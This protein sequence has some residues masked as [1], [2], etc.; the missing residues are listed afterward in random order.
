MRAHLLAIL[1]FTGT[2]VA[3]DKKPDAPPSDKKPDAPPSE[4]KPA[5]PPAD[6]PKSGA[7]AEVKAGT[8]VEKHE[9]VGEATSFSKDS[10]VFAWSRVVN[11]EPSVKHVWKLNGKEVWSKSLNVGSKRWATFTRNTLRT[12][13]NWEVDVQTEAGESI[14]K[15]AFTVQ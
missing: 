14:G 6:T 11:G 9:V 8:G 15:I 13:G 4:A 3:D 12:A 7:S 1:L 2:A 10:V 5:P